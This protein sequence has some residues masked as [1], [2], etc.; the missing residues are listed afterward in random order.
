MPSRL[1]KEGEASGEGTSVDAGI[2]MMV[3][4]MVAE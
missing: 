4:W 3:E 1:S 2:F